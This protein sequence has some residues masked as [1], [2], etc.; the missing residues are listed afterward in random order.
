MAI[1]INKLDVINEKYI[2]KHL[3]MADVRNII[4]DFVKDR[5]HLDNVA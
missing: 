3:I 2:N 4:N 1:V 5:I